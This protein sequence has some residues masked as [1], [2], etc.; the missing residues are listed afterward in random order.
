MNS[1]RSQKKNLANFKFSLFGLT[2]PVHFVI[3]FLRNLEQI[4]SGFNESSSALWNL[5]WCLMKLTIYL[6]LLL[7]NSKCSFF[8]MA[9]QKFQRKYKRESSLSEKCL[10]LASVIGV[11]LP[12]FHIGTI[13]FL[14]LIS[15]VF[16]NFIEYFICS[17]FMSILT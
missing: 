2:I 4:F 6:H 11:C 8:I 15:I 16:H 10:L 12:V 5:T 14:V 9:F 1:G 17:A 13:E 3:Q 7:N